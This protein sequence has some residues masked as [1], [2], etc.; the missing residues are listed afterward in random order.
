MMIQI[1]INVIFKEFLFNKLFLRLDGN[2]RR[3]QGNLQRPRPVLN[4]QNGNNRRNAP[5]ETNGRLNSSNNSEAINI[6]RPP[7]SQS[8][9]PV[10]T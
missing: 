4:Y 6:Y 3:P 7:P 9:V 8:V 1:I 5:K 2:R 10:Q